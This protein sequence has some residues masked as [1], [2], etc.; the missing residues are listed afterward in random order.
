MNSLIYTTSKNGN[1][2]YIDIS[3]KIVGYAHPLLARIHALEKENEFFR[4]MPDSIDI[5]GFGV[6]RAYS[7]T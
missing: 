1:N 2:Y 7:S 3:K 4:E 6:F 5:E